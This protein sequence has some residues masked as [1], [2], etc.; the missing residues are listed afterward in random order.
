M[1]LNSS[2]EPSLYICPVSNVL[3]SVPI[4]PLTPI[5]TLF[6][7]SPWLWRYGRGQPRKVSVAEAEARR[8]ELLSQTRE[9]VAKTLKRRK[10]ERGD[11]FYKRQHGRQAAEADGQ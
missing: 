10:E 2:N 7:V 6:E 1:L 4:I 9:Q 8:H 11:E 5:L 3:G